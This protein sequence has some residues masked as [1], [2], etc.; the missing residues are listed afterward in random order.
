MTSSRLSTSR[1]SDGSE[2]WRRADCAWSLAAVN[3]MNTN[4]TMKT[5][6]TIAIAT[7]S[8]HHF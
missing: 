1:Q 3:T 2:N 6:P 8:I 4:G 7:A 5:I